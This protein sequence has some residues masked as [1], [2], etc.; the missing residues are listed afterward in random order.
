MGSEPVPTTP[1]SHTRSLSL[2]AV[3]IVLAA[4][5]AIVPTVGTVSPAAVHLVHLGVLTLL[6]AALSTRVRH[7]LFGSALVL[8]AHPPVGL[9]WVIGPFVYVPLILLCRRRSSWR[10]SALSG[11][12]FGWSLGYVLAGWS[13]ITLARPL[14]ADVTMLLVSGSLGA[15]V[16]VGIRAAALLPP[17]ARFPATAAIIVAMEWGRCW[18]QVVSLPYFLTAHL[19]AENPYLAQWSEVTGFWGL[20]VWTVAASVVAAAAIEQPSLR[21]RTAGL[22]AIALC[23]ALGGGAVRYHS[24]NAPDSRTVRVLVVQDDNSRKPHG[25]DAASDGR[26]VLARLRDAVTSTDRPDF[27]LLPEGTIVSGW[28]EQTAD[29]EV[30]AEPDGVTPERLQEVIADWRGTEGP[31]VVAG[32]SLM[33]PNGAR[34]NSVCLFAEKAVTPSIVR[35]KVMKAP[36]G[37]SVP[38]EGIPLLEAV[39]GTLAESRSE[40]A[41]VDP[42]AE[43]DHNGVRFAVCVCFEHVLP[44]VWHR[45]HLSDPSEID[46]QAAFGDMRWFEYSPVE[47][48]QSRPAR[49]LHAIMNRV[50]FVYV[51]NGG[52]E[53][54]NIRGDVVQTLRPDSA[55][56][57]FKVDVP[58]HGHSP[59]L[60]GSGTWIGS[61]SLGAGFVV[62]ALFGLVAPVPSRKD[63]VPGSAPAVTP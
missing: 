3:G 32:A 44:D 58:T 5:L 22:L 30:R 59:W 39:G 56:G 4:G 17:A 13:T 51:A 26:Q 19:V 12:F 14:L 57:E 28:V 41:T 8:V 34:R 23:L 1:A 55:F 25:I 24:L 2:R 31:P 20:T 38:F 47:R 27:V 37:E 50:P 33:L 53:W 43:I 45:H 54:V 52:S 6:I 9:G 10:A 40:L 63:L 15:L 7:D 11:A 42:F 35:D 60:G 18:N 49:R 16:S 48:S 46:I 21:P 62:L 36:I 61:L 29:G